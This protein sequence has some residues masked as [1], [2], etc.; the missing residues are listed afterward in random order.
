M[1]SILAAYDISRHSDWTTD[2]EALSEDQLHFLEGNA[3][4]ST[5][6]RHLPAGAGSPCRRTL[7][8]SGGRCPTTVRRKSP[9][10]SS[11]RSLAAQLIHQLLAQLDVSPLPGLRGGIAQDCGALVDVT[12][13]HKQPLTSRLV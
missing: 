8:S 5:E 10:E 6:G 1:K 9:R 4:S 3:Q 13:T 11:A 12:T 7:L 2:A